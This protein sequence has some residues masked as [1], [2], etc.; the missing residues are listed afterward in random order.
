MAQRPPSSGELGYR[1]DSAS[2]V[3]LVPGRVQV[4]TVQ[5]LTAS[6]SPV[7]DFFQRAFIAHS[8]ACSGP[9]AKVRPVLNRFPAR[10][11]FFRSNFFREGEFPC[12]IILNGERFARIVEVS[13]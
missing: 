4:K 6:G 13:R 7:T 1:F 11:G 3:A 12:F 5:C 9:V 8:V 10:R 2:R